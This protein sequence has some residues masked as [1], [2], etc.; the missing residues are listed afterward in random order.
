MDAGVLLARARAHTHTHA[1][2]SCMFC[3]V[4]QHHMPSLSFVRQYILSKQRSLFISC[5]FTLMARVE[6][7]ASGQMTRRFSLGGERK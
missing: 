6:Q 3:I 7:V 4:L 5:A 2:L 1:R